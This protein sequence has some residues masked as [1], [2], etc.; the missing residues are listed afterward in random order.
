MPP[1]RARR[2]RVK[3]LIFVVSWK[4]YLGCI[5]D[6]ERKSLVLDHHL[7]AYAHLGTPI[8]VHG[9]ES[10]EMVWCN[11]S[12]VEFWQ[13]ESI[14]ALLSSGLSGLCETALIQMAGMRDR[15]RTEGRVV[16]EWTFCLGGDPLTTQ[17]VCSP[18]GP[19]EDVACM[20]VEAQMVTAYQRDQQCMQDRFLS[21]V[22][23]EL[24]TPLTSARG[25]IL[26]LDQAWERFDEVERR[27][28]VAMVRRNTDQLLQL[29]NELL[30]VQAMQSGGLKLN[31]KPLGVGVWLRRAVEINRHLGLP[32]EVDFELVLAAGLG[33]VLGHSERLTQALGNLLS[34]AAK[35]SPRGGRVTVK[36]EQGPYFVRVIV[37]DCGE[38]I[39]EAFRPRVFDRFTQAEHPHVRSTSGT[40]LGLNIAR[41]LVEAHGGEIG[42]ES[43][44]GR[45][46]S[47]WIRLPRIDPDSGQELRAVRV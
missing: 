11:D 18:L 26:M 14:E 10:G 31:R 32:Y 37:E 7:D 5:L 15:L 44:E 43:R 24:R 38:G 8:W 17:V 45:G 1:R 27:G 19:A 28:L 4:Y 21:V 29:V 33:H 22:S 20:L 9:F 6:S 2:F 40:G 13:A 16:E 12:A 36:C 41:S 3:F 23:H 35:F 39:P 30:D 34:N 25:A 46:T 47:F 42:F